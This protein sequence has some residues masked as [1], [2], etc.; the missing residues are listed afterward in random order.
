MLISIVLLLLPVAVFYVG[1][2]IG[3]LMSSFRLF[4]T[5]VIVAKCKRSKQRSISNFAMEII[6]YVTTKAYIIE[7]QI[8]RLKLHSLKL[9]PLMTTVSWKNIRSPSL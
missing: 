6:L 9:D 8:S 3:N 5:H 7:I 2:N 4:G 1:V